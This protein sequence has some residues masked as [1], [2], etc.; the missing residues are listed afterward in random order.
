MDRIVFGISARQHG[1]VTRK[2]LL[3]SGVG[4]GAI[5]GRVAKGA[6]RPVHR[7]VYAVAG[8]PLAREG[9][10]L[11]AVLACEGATLSHWDAAEL[12]SIVPPRTSWRVHV[13]VLPND[14]PTQRHGIRLH[15]VP[16][17]AEDKSRRHNIPV[18]APARTLFDLAPQ[19]PRRRLDRALDE[20][21]YLHLL[22]TGVLEATLQRRGVSS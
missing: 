12:W 14:R 22:P 4:E 15:R 21:A 7:G 18:T 20:A 19:M 8:R 10:W 6:L 3:G 2:Q 16:L 1:V 5:E 11:A 13:S 17:S 9:R